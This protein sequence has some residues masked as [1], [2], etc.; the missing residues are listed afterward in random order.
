MR[1]AAYNKQR[2]SSHVLVMPLASVSMANSRS[3]VLLQRSRKLSHALRM[4]SAHVHLH[5]HYPGSALP[6]ALPALA[7]GC[8]R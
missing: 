2:R 8:E 7:L 5:S 1:S 3:D 6:L 4:L